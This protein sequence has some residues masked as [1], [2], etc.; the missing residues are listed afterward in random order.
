M[1]AL[2]VRIK[3]AF[4]RYIFVLDCVSIKE[5]VKVWREDLFF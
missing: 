2:I 4:R 3:W 1:K 5:G